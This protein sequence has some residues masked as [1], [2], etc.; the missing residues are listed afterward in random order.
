MTQPEE[1]TILTSEIFQLWGQRAALYP[2]FANVWRDY[3]LLMATFQAALMR[4][5]RTVEACAQVDIERLL[6]AELEHLA[7]TIAAIFPRGG[8]EEFAS[9]RTGAQRTIW[10]EMQPPEPATKAQDAEKRSPAYLPRN[11]TVGQ[12]SLIMTSEDFVNGY[13]AGYLSSLL[14][15]RMAHLTDEA[16]ITLILE[17]L[18]RKDASERYRA[19]YVVGWIV[20]LTSTKKSEGLF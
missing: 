18:A 20:A 1:T 2:E 9:Y 19:G 16:L 15:A 4:T 8:M 3:A 6:I 17:K 14:G 11:I 12:G 10:P 13:H 5:P 7:D